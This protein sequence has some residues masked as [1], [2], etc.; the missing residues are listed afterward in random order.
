VHLL[1]WERSVLLRFLLSNGVKKDHGVLVLGGQLLQVYIFLLFA[2]SQE[3]SSGYH[4]LARHSSLF[5]ALIYP[6]GFLV[7]A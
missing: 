3:F 5:L 2:W 7:F 1:R 6:L 4:D